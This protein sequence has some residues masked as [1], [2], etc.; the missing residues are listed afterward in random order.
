MKGSQTEKIRAVMDGKYASM[1]GESTSKR[2]NGAVMGLVGGLLLGS[3]LRQ[4]A[5]MVGIAG[6][7]IG[8]VIGNR[9]SDI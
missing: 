3:L 5:I 4:N 2:M 1:V 6:G 7:I 8:Y 9:N